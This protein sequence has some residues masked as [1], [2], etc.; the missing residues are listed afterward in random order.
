MLIVM[1]E[2]GAAAKR[3]IRQQRSECLHTPGQPR[4]QPP[5]YKH[6]N[7]KKIAVDALGASMLVTILL[8]TWRITFGGIVPAQGGSK[9]SGG[10]MWAR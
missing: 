10:L 6:A 5:P 4:R 7:H 9:A 8:D 1:L 3:W 2:K